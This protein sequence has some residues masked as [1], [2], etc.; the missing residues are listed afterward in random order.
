MLMEPNLMTTL[1][2]NITTILLKIMTVVLLNNI[3]IKD[4][5]NASVINK[6]MIK[7][8]KNQA[9]ENLT[10]PTIPT[11]MLMV[12]SSILDKFASKLVSTSI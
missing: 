3:T 7:V 4:L 5:S 10:I 11:L 6:L 12:T 9:L 2:L 8:T 1:L